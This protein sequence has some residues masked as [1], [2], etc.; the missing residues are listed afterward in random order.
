VAILLWYRLRIR[1]EGSPEIAA[2]LV[3]TAVQGD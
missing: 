2:E 1:A 3:D